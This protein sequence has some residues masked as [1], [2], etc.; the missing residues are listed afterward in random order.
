MKKLPQF[1]GVMFRVSRSIGRKDFPEAIQALEDCVSRDPLDTATLG[2]L[3][4]CHRWSGSDDK[5]LEVAERVLGI[6]PHDFSSLKLL[7]EILAHRGEHQL[8]VAYVRRGLEQYPEEM[9]PVSPYLVTLA[10]VVMRILRPRR[11][12]PAEDFAPWERING[13]NREW[14]EW[15]KRYLAWFDSDTG[16]STL[17]ALH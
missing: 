3:A 10:K 8:A 13:K 11:S 4:E 6:D 15:A 16:S 14:F 1:A 7:S 12:I 9:D 5:A 2:L 17:P